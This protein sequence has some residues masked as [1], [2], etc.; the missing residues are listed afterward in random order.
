VSS[1]GDLIGFG[2]EGRRF[3][4]NR[5]EISGNVLI[6]VQAAWERR[7][8]AGAGF[9]G[10]APVVR[11]APRR[12]A[13]C[14]RLAGWKPALPVVP[15]FS[16]AVWIPRRSIQTRC[17]NLVLVFLAVLPE[18]RLIGAIGTLAPDRHRRLLGR[19][20]TYPAPRQE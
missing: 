16:P 13:A 12:Q 17:L 4:D 5:I 11:D 9:I 7:P 18:S 3:P 19:L 20:A 1:S 2:L 15:N 10:V 8:L 6:P 14:R